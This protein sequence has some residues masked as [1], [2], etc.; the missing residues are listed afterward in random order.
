M[1]KQLWLK[2]LLYAIR[3]YMLKVFTASFMKNKVRKKNS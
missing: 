2:M 1:N 3:K